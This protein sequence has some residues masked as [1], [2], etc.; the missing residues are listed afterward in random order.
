VI[1]VMLI[2]SFAIAGI[3]ILGSYLQ[4]Q[5]TA[6]GW[7]VGFASELLWII[8]GLLTG[9][10]GLAICGFTYASVAVR[11]FFKWRREALDEEE[12]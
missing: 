10:W 9:Q 3:G 6:W 2:T 12:T 5:K 8:S 7:A 4:G 11:N 1:T